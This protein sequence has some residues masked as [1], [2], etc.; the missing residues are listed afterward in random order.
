MLNNVDV[1]F[2]CETWAPYV[3]YH[4]LGRGIPEHLYEVDQ[5]S[6]PNQV[7]YHSLI[8]SA[9]FMV[10]KTTPI[11]HLIVPSAQVPPHKLETSGMHRRHFGTQHT[12]FHGAG[13]DNSDQGM[14]FVRGISE[15]SMTIYSFRPVTAVTLINE[16]N[17]V[18]STDN[19]AFQR[20]LSVR[21]VST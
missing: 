4:L 6:A 14:I 9:T 10:C 3:L 15:L 11:N 13:Q 8:S 7:L 19:C 5:N 2:M 12:T 20:T 16:L 17:W 18:V 1:A 21:Y